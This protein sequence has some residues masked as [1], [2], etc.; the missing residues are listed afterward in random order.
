[1]G[2]SDPKEPC[3]DGALSK[4]I[5]EQGLPSRPATRLWTTVNHSGGRWGAG[6]RVLKW[7]LGQVP[8]LHFL[9]GGF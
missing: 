4:R 1:M 3:P 9:M 5:S 6:G 7:E 8:A 2:H